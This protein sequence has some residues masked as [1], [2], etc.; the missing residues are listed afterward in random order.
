MISAEVELHTD[1]GTT[2]KVTV[3]A[4][5]RE[6]LYHKVEE[7]VRL[8][9]GAT[10]KR[11]YDQGVASFDRLSK[12]LFGDKRVTI[13]WQGGQSEEM[14]VDCSREAI[15]A[16]VDLIHFEQSGEFPEHKEH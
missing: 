1:Q 4:E 9:V 3:T 12:L 10:H 7:R 6:L 15:L 14:L 16:T 2:P 8:T 5:S 11:A 13:Y